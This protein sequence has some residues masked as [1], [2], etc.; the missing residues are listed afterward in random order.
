MFDATPGTTTPPFPHSTVAERIAARASR[1]PDAPAL[2][3]GTRTLSFGGLL[4]SMRTTAGRLGARGVRPGDVVAV[5]G[6]RSVETVAACAGVM[7]A[8]AAYLVL[9]PSHPAERLRALLDDSG[10][11]AVVGAVP[12]AVRGGPGRPPPLVELGP[13]GAGSEPGTAAP[14]RPPGGGAAPAYVNYTS[15]S[16]GRPKGVVVGHEGLSHL[17]DWF[18][19]RYDAGPG[20]RLS[21]LARPTFDAFVLETW[22]GLC[23]GASVH[24]TPDEALKDPELLRDWLCHA[25]ITLSFVPTPLAEQLLALDWP[26]PG[27]ACALR[28]LL[29][30]GDRMHRR[31][32][33]GLPFR[34]HNNYGPTECTVVATCWLVS[35]ADERPVTP[36]G[37]A[38]GGEPPPIGRPLPQVTAHVLGPDGTPVPVGTTGELH[39]GGPQLAH[40][41]AGRP[42]GTARAF[43]PDPFR[44]GTGA[45]LYATG[46]LVRQDAEGV[47]HYL[48]RGDDQIQIRGIRV[49]PAETETVLRAHPALAQ[50][51]VVGTDEPEPRLAAFVTTL[52]DGVGTRE[53]HDWAA[54]RLP[55]FLLPSL[56]TVVPEI[57][58]TPQ[59][60][61]DR[62]ALSRRPLAAAHSP[63]APPPLGY[64]AHSPGAHGD[65]GAAAVLDVLEPLWCEVLGTP[66][67]VLGDDFF[68]VGGD[69]LRVIRLVSRARRQGLRLRPEDVYAH[70]VLA[71]LARAVAPPA[72]GTP[73]PHSAPEEASP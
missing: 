35:P 23:A 53:I 36:A 24:I 28:D 50:A 31:P 69:S 38:A 41:Y 48:G 54:R 59:G 61:V 45:R 26:A 4:S 30:G 42:A 63:E 6:Q 70:P 5:C 14:T 39:L 19:E 72:E 2:V 49:E 40:G 9:D 58:L 10:A 21:Q 57:P 73:A 29:V 52:R 66:A 7:A 44:P 71:D 22:T 15:G 13:L 67:A 60:K 11:R 43:R 27:A 68:E 1:R 65:D 56:V 3:D 47:L 18:Q 64:P 46:D 33:A 20:D 16:S 34:V 37:G 17:V 25:G 62:A 12:P 32:P 8:G 55:E 51:V